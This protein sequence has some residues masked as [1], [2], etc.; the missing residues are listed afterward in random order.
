MDPALF[1]TAA[2]LLRWR[3]RF[4][5]KPFECGLQPHFG[6]YNQKMQKMAMSP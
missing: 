3:G 4:H 5:V 1:C 2:F 6:I